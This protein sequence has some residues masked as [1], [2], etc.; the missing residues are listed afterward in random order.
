MKRRIFYNLIII[1]IILAGVFGFF[2]SKNNKKYSVDYLIG[3]SESNLNE[4][5][6]SWRI[7][8][9][10]QN[11][12]EYANVKLI[13]L[14][15]F[16]SP[17]KQISDIETLLGYGVDMLLVSPSDSVILTEIVERAYQNI[18]VIILDNLIETDKYTMFFGVDNHKIGEMGKGMVAGSANGVLEI[19]GSTPS[20]TTKLRSDGF[21][22]DKNHSFGAEWLTA[23]AEERTARFIDEVAQ[24]ENIFVHNN[25]MA[26]GAVRAIRSKKIKCN[27]VSVS[28]YPGDELGINMLDGNMIEGTIVIKD[29]QTPLFSHILNIMN[30]K[31]VSKNIFLECEILK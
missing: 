5:W 21:F 9:I 6:A 12:K 27:V 25:L 29:Y 8:N 15:A 13:I 23:T 24:V 10:K 18:P 19:K 16:D 31:E 11:L 17:N 2:A 14:N 3:I 22:R 1:F 20:L 4:P 28:S 7:K 26:Y 30:G